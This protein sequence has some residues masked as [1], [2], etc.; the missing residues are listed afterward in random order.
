MKKRVLRAF[1]ALVL[2]SLL[3]AALAPAA[4]AGG[5]G[6]RFSD[7]A[8]FQPGTGAVL[9]A[10]GIE[11]VVPPHA[12][13]RARPLRL[14][15]FVRDGQTVVMLAPELQFQEPVLIDFGTEPLVFYWDNGQWVTVK[16]IDAD[17]DGAVGEILV[18]HS[19][20]WG[21]WK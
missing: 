10:G 17:Q 16:T 13:D 20:R 19:S 5:G 14:M 9:E 6:E 18:D 2:V 12:L 4:Y 1:T 11:V 3:L 7:M 8:W 21:W 15:V